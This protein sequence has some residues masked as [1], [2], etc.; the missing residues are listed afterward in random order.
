[1][2]NKYNLKGHLVWEWYTEWDQVYSR[3]K[4]NW[5]TGTIVHWYFE[6]EHFGYQCQFVLFGFGFYFRYNT[7]K[8]LKLFAKWHK[9]C[10]KQSYEFVK[11]IKEPKTVKKTKKVK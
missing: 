4:F 1:M 6:Y 7:D 8:S 9:E 2:K 11:I 3:K 5:Y 10:E